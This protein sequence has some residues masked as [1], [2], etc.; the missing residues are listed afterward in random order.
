MQLAW[1]LSVGRLCFVTR[2]AYLHRLRFLLILSVIIIINNAATAV[3][4][5]AAAA[6]TV[7]VFTYERA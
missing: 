6:W 4:A 7:A 3:A 1:D 2:D 5:A